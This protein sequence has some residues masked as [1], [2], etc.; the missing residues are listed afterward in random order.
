MAVEIDAFTASCFARSQTSRREP[1]GRL[2]AAGARSVY[3]Q[4]AM[5]GTPNAVT[6][7][8]ETSTAI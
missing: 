3:S 4:K 5:N 6:F 7:L 8:L 1:A 2:S